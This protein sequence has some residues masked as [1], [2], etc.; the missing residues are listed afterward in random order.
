MDIRLCQSSQKL[1]LRLVE[2]F[3][4]ALEEG[5]DYIGKQFF[6][7]SIDPKQTQNDTQLHQPLL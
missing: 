3:E 5:I 6:G 7:Q 1:K 2:S 4:V